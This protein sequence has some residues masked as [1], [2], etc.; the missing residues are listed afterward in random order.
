VGF[1]GSDHEHDDGL[2]EESHDEPAGAEHDGGRVEREQKYSEG[3]KV[4]LILLSIVVPYPPFVHV[5]LRALAGSAPGRA[6]EFAKRLF[7]RREA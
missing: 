5:R 1:T 4:A 7:Y 3:Q 2:R 6:V